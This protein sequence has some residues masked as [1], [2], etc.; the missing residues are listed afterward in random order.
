MPTEEYMQISV[1][2]ARFFCE[3]INRIVRG[4]SEGQWDLEE[5]RRYFRA[6]MHCWKSVVY[7][8]REEKGLNK[9]QFKRWAKK[10]ISTWNHPDSAY[11]E[12]VW[13]D[14]RCTRDYDTHK[15]VI[16]VDREVAVLSPIV[17]FDPQG[18]GAGPRRELI[19]CCER[20]VVIAERLIG[21]Y[22]QIT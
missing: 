15:K 2:D 22:R 16:I 7:F 8:V 1:D 4:Q 21:D 10:W 17:M 3:H 11:D 9:K 12:Q 20:G 6:F 19:S 14:L 13:N 5:V 18:K